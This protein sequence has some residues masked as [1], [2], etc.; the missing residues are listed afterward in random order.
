MSAPLLDIQGLSI[1][2]RTRE[3]LKRVVADVSFTV[4]AGEALGIV[5]ESGSG[6][7]L[8]MLSLLQLLPSGAVARADRAWYDGRDLF[9]QSPRQMAAIRGREIAFVFQDSLTALNPVR[10]IGRQITEVLRLHFSLSTAD[11]ERRAA[12]LLAK[13]G[14]PDPPLRLRQYPHE[15]SGGM[16]QRVCI[17]MALAG[18][19]RVLIADEP[20]T[21][22]DVTV[23]ADIVNLIQ[24]LQRDSGLTVIWVTH[25]LALLARL[26]DR[27]IVMYGGR[28]MEDASAPE[29][30]AR[31]SHPYAAALLGSVRHEAA[32]RRPVGVRATERHMAPGAAAVA[33]QAQ[34][35]AAPAAAGCPFAPRCPEAAAACRSNA[36]PL[37]AGAL[38]TRV[39][40]WA[41]GNPLE[42]AAPAASVVP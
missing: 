40:C 35:V 19:P 17:A 1:S 13:V 2:L 26:A 33:E 6:K 12:E 25:D 37:R 9:G 8:S 14:I 39:A 15:F 38:G 30:F 7:T 27:V 10:S 4:A 36:P 31:P 29:L 21:A 3:G 20:T 5:G 42:S 18:E 32:A 11:A 24:Q 23:Q 22:L 16:R 28:V 34:A 41:R